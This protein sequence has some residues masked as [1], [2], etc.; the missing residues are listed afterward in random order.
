M[1]SEAKTTSPGPTA[2][3]G[4]LGSERIVIPAQ[5]TLPLGKG[6]PDNFD[7]DPK[8]GRFMST[9][10]KVL[11]NVVFS[12]LSK[13]LAKRLN[14]D[15]KLSGL[16]IQNSGCFCLIRGLVPIPKMFFSDD[17]ILL[18]SSRNFASFYFPQSLKFLLK[19]TSTFVGEA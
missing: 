11:V 15:I 8:T 18:I 17:S 10:G 14:L 4:E 3:T 16:E 7:T 2:L 5:E 12:S 9:T 1:K 13:K 19:R 6:S